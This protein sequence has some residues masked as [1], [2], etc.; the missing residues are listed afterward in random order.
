MSRST[1][2]APLSPSD[3]QR[4]D[5]EALSSSRKSPLREI[6]RARILLAYADRTSIKEIASQVGV[7][8]LTV[9]IYGPFARC[10]RFFPF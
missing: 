5:L 4:K 3:E 10:K 1:Q 2:R 9:Y 6:Q 7:Q 8:R